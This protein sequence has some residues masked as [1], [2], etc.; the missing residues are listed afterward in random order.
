M[1]PGLDT[2]AWRTSWCLSLYQHGRLAVVVWLLR[3]Q[4]GDGLHDA[5]EP[6]LLGAC[7]ALVVELYRGRG[8]SPKVEP[9]EVLLSSQCSSTTDER[10]SSRCCRYARWELG[11]CRL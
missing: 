10:T 2:W 3:L 9:P 4:P 5:L 7:A 6:R 11:F 1:K 8:S